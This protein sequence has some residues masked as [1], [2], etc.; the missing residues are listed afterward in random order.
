LPEQS[1]KDLQQ[2]LDAAG[3]EAE[4]TGIFD[5]ATRAALIA[6]QKARRL[7]ADGIAGPKTW[8]ALRKP[9]ETPQAE[10]NWLLAFLHFITG[11]FAWRKS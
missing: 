6:F 5:A 7:A 4:P 11:L 10:P 1:V 2:A 3:F 9:A 8:A